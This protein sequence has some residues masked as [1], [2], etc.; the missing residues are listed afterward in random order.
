M[1]FFK[2]LTRGLSIFFTSLN[3]LLG[4]TV[5]SVFGSLCALIVMLNV[6]NDGQMSEYWQWWVGPGAVL[7]A[8]AGIKVWPL[9]LAL[10][11]GATADAGDIDSGFDFSGADG[12]EP[13]SG[14]SNQNTTDGKGGA[15]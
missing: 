3:V 11:F 9:M 5:G 10:F 2:Y 13:S 1:K 12:T 4:I 6:G 7:G 15:W 14:G 8:I